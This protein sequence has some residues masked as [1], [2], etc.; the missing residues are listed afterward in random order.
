MVRNFGWDKIMLLFVFQS[1]DSENLPARVSL[2][3]KNPSG[4]SN[5]FLSLSH[6]MKK[7][8]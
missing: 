3:F 6:S 2:H 5:P 7:F 8:A 4:A 1:A